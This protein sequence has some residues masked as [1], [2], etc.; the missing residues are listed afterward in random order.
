MGI[1]MYWSIN[2]INLL[3]LKTMLTVMYIIATISNLMYII[4][5]LLDISS[6]K[7]M[8]STHFGYGSIAILSMWYILPMYSF[9]LAC[10]II[11][12]SITILISKLTK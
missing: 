2:N 10:L 8:E 11:P 9:A 1:Y 12:Y 3:K 6:T 7:R 5:M 4:N